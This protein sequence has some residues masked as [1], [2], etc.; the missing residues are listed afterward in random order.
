MRG[1]FDVLSLSGTLSCNAGLDLKIMLAD[2]NGKVFGGTVFG[3][4]TVET[5]IVL[6]LGISKTESYEKVMDVNTGTNEIKVTYLDT[7]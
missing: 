5:S 6:V 1:R 4:H 3:D 7:E 2:E